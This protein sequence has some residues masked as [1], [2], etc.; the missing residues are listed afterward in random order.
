MQDRRGEHWCH[1]ILPAASCQ[2][3]EQAAAHAGSVQATCYAGIACRHGKP[4]FVLV[5]GGLPLAVHTVLSA[6]AQHQQSPQE[7]EIPRGA[8][9]RRMQRLGRHELICAPGTPS[10]EGTMMLLKDLEDFCWQRKRAI[11][12][13]RM[14]VSEAGC[15]VREGSSSHSWGTQELKR[16]LVLLLFEKTLT[17]VSLLRDVPSVQFS[18]SCVCFTQSSLRKWLGI[19]KSMSGLIHACAVISRRQFKALTVDNFVQE[20]DRLGIAGGCSKG[21][22]LVD[23]PEVFESR[24]ELTI[25]FSSFFLLCELQEYSYLG[26]TI[27]NRMSHSQEPESLPSQAPLSG[28]L[29]RGVAVTARVMACACGRCTEGILSPRLRFVMAALADCIAEMMWQVCNEQFIPYEKMK[30]EF[31]SGDI[32]LGFTD[33]DVREAGV[34]KSFYTGYRYVFREIARLLQERPDFVPTEE[35]VSNALKP[36]ALTYNPDYT[37]A[38]FDFFF[39]KGGRPGAHGGRLVRAEHLRGGAASEPGRRPV[40]PLGASHPPTRRLGEARELR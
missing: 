39:K 11:V 28:S 20:G 25:R 14:A 16:V 22:T 15:Q 40:E 37:S 38:Y 30:E 19:S 21:K 13:C 10:H 4:S 27:S 31:V 17:I 2:G 33:E 1:S 32:P 24:I 26:L 7:T 5:G 6:E 18:T 36:E 23:S 8:K 3:L 9:S 35:N 12:A 29:N 34:Y